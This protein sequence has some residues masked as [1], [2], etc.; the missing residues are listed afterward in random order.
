MFDE[1]LESYIVSNC[2]STITYKYEICVL[3]FLL[4]SQRGTIIIK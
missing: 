4:R 2:L 1:G 3:Y